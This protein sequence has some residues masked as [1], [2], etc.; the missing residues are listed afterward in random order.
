MIPRKL[1]GRNGKEEEEDEE[2]RNCCPSVEVEVS[3]NTA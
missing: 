1:K 2:G 3:T